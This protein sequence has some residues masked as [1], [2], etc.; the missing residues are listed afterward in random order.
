MSQALQRSQG[1]IPNSDV[2]ITI[3]EAADEQEQQELFQQKIKELT[4]RYGAVNNIP[5]NIN[6]EI[7]GSGAPSVSSSNQTNNSMLLEPEGSEQDRSFAERVSN[8]FRA[9]YRDYDRTVSNIDD[10]GYGTDQEI[11]SAL[12][13]EQQ[14]ELEDEIKFGRRTSFQDLLDAYSSPNKD[15]LAKGFGGTLIDYAGENVAY[16]LP[17]MGPVALGAAA[18]SFIPGLGTLAGA[19]VGATLAAFPYFFGQNLERQVETLDEQGLDLTDGNINTTGAAITA[20]TQGAT[21]SLLFV[22]FGGMGGTPAKMVAG[23]LRKNLGIAAKEVAKTTAVS[24][25]TEAATE[26]TQQFL[27]RLQ[28]GLPISPS[29]EAAL[30]EYIES[31]VAG[32]ITGP[33][34]TGP[35]E[36]GRQTF[37][38]IT[39]Q[40]SQEQVKNNYNEKIQELQEELN[41]HS[42]NEPLD[43]NSAEYEQ[44]SNTKE[45]M[46]EVLV[47]VQTSLK[48]FEEGTI[49]EKRK[50][51]KAENGEDINKE[52]QFEFDLPE[53]PYKF[54]DPTIKE[55]EIKNSVTAVPEVVSFNELPGDAKVRLFFGREETVKDETGKIVFNDDGE[56]LTEIITLKDKDGFNVY[57]DYMVEEF[58]DTPDSKVDKAEPNERLFSQM[59]I[60]H[61]GK[62][63]QPFWKRG[64]PSFAEIQMSKEPLFRVSSDNK[65]SYNKIKPLL[66]P[67]KPKLRKLAERLGIKYTDKTLDEQQEA[68]SWLNHITARGARFFT[69]QRGVPVVPWSELMRKRWFTREQLEKA[70]T[71]SKRVD[72]GIRTAEKSKKSILNT[73]E[74]SV[75]GLGLGKELYASYLSN[76]PFGNI[77]VTP[78]LL[79]EY[80]FDRN[81]IAA[82][83]KMRRLID[84]NSR[85]IESLI[86]ELDP[87]TEI[88]SEEL[89]ET[90]R[91]RLGA[92]ITKSYEMNVNPEYI[93]ND[94]FTLTF[95][96]PN[97]T[98]ASKE[99]KQ[100]HLSAKK[101]LSEDL[102][103]KGRVSS[104]FEAD[105]KAEEMLNNLYDRQLSAQQLTEAM[106]MDSSTRKADAKE[107]ELDISDDILKARKELKPEIEELLGAI[108][109]PNINDVIT[110]FKQTEFISGVK[111]MNDL[112]NIANDPN[113]RLISQ[114]KDGRF[115]VRIT[116]NEVSNPFV[117]YYTIPEFASA[118]NDVFNGGILSDT[119]LA[120]RT[121]LGSNRGARYILDKIYAPYFLRG[122]VLINFGKIVISPATQAR[123]FVSAAGFAIVNGNIRLNPK[124]NYNNLKSAFTNAGSYFKGMT[125]KQAQRMI[126]LG[127]LNTSANLGDLIR[128]FELAS[129]TDTIGGV[130]ASVNSQQKN[131]LRRLTK[132]TIDSAQKAYQFGDDFWKAY[133]FVTELQ[134]FK[135]I[136]GFDSFKARHET[137]TKQATEGLQKGKN[138]FV[139]IDIQLQKL[140]NDLKQIETVVLKNLMPKYVPKLKQTKG[141][142]RLEEL[143]EELAAYRVRQNVPNYDF[144]GSFTDILRGSPLSNFTAFPTEIIRTSINT[145]QSGVNEFKAGQELKKLGRDQ[146]GSGE[147]FVNIGTKL[148]SRGAARVL[149]LGG[150]G[151]LAAGS[152]TFALL[153]LGYDAE[154]LPEAEFGLSEFMP[155]YAK[156]DKRIITGIN[157][158]GEVFYNNNS[159]I[160]AYDLLAE[161]VR[162]FLRNMYEETYADDPEYVKRS[163]DGMMEALNKTFGLESAYF[164]KSI[165]TQILFDVSQNLKGSSVAAGDPKTITDEKGMQGA[166]DKIIYA[167]EEAAPGI[168]TYFKNIDTLVEGD[169][170]DQYGRKIQK[171]DTAK[172]LFGIK[173]GTLNLNDNMAV[174]GLN[175]FIDKRQDASSEYYIP[176]IQAGEELLT[177]SDMVQ[178]YIKANKKY[179]Q[180]VER[181]RNKIER[182]NGVN[183]WVTDQSILLEIRRRGK[184]KRFRKGDKSNIFG[185]PNDEG[186]VK[187]RPLPY[188]DYYSK[189]KREYLD[190]Y[191]KFGMT[192]KYQEL[193][194]MTFPREALKQQF[195]IFSTLEFSAYDFKEPPAGEEVSF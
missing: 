12:R 167:L 44:W 125:T 86:R 29:D 54:D 187:F 78:R 65:P 166:F 72:L 96:R 73:L 67:S 82:M 171:T 70:K 195:D 10:F 144:V 52:K 137:L 88:W 2:F 180:E 25:P 33:A 49:I 152:S 34:V 170:F 154:D 189:V 66:L 57:K 28:A 176:S 148:G 36:T 58:I 31:G 173:S 22:L 131:I 172:Q 77:K 18:G 53:A 32:F 174:W 182:A 38:G 179:Y 81:T 157:N 146:E 23:E 89:R 186:M 116:G 5:T 30:R 123:N 124:D 149:S 143:L 142:A 183:P 163:L 3:L 102:F 140:E 145:Y 71:L 130:V 56:A 84:Q 153:M 26:I 134:K 103:K 51:E 155:Y 9:G 159:Y 135:D 139:E 104:K 169:K 109:D 192:E 158:K 160:E 14:A 59:Q 184:V 63:Y 91:N 8:S 106:E 42:K 40:P 141:P 68:R 156:D 118:L 19:G 194:K 93:K 21:E 11:E 150:Y 13:A 27:E 48:S 126:G 87:E 101:V 181:F 76:T 1:R 83:I 129:T 24:A 74:Q 94:L 80:G 178:G 47:S 43:S 136:F 95:N 113:N 46:E 114:V 177:T 165:L 50:Q 147:G 120:D 132:K 20:L 108:K 4:N 37:R 193:N 121:P 151:A 16:S 98:L 6:F 138:D 188:K 190:K 17:A 185:R 112:F 162:V 15:D 133:S 175:N 69:P 119:T 164:T 168:Y 35:L 191:K 122:K 90:I 110:A 45:K 161:P 105:K 64:T 100:K 97:G 55:T 75:D 39:A 128:G 127:V 115:N 41:N 61:E 60:E 92:Y 85:E 99:Q 79:E 117:G 107:I 7:T 111:Y 62:T